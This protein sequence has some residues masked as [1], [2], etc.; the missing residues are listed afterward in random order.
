[1]EYKEFGVYIYNG[2][3]VEYHYSS[4]A[5]YME[6]VNFVKFVTDTVVNDN[7]YI[8]LLK[9][10]IF[11]LCLVK[12]FTDIDFSIFSKD[13]NKLNIDEFAEFDEITNVS[14]FLKAKIDSEI[15]EN[16]INSVEDNLAYITGIRRDS[17]TT[18]I[19]NLINTAQ[20]K[21]ENFGEGL[22]SK[23]VIEFMENF[24]K[25]NLNEKNIVET[26]LKSDLHKNKL[27]EVIDSK[28][29]QITKLKEK[30]KS[31]PVNVLSDK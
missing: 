23:T 25:S 20:K 31:V 5:S 30:S 6:Q 28:N 17:I 1:M 9:N 7:Q 12:W 27:N 4:S 21:I 18:S 2:K 26:Y 3:D 16:L 19:I 8:P 29:Q 11:N 10:I 22:D 14:D 15:I 24:K 13:T